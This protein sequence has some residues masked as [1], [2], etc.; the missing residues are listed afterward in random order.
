M[1]RRML[2]IV[3]GIGLT[4]ALGPG[5]ATAN[6]PL[7]PP[8]T[9]LSGT[10]IFTLFQ[11]TSATTAIGAGVVQS[12]GHPVG[13][14]SANYFDVVQQGQGVI[15]LHGQ[16]AISLSEGTLL[17]YDEIHLQSDNKNPAVF[18]ANARLYVVGGGTGAYSEATG[19]LHSH[20]E[21]N[22][23]TLE[24]GIDFKGQVCVP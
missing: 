17:T 19:L 3:L 16:H 22:V 20:G 7:T 1:N 21:L 9:P 11:F 13:T 14:F 4:L 23:V 24:G 2:M 6:S 12:E 8:C 18:Q 15:Q 10:F 5:K